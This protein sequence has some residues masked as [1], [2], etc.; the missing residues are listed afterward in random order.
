MGFRP[1]GSKRVIC[2]ILE[3]C[4][5][6]ISRFPFWSKKFKIFA[7]SGLTVFFQRFCSEY[8]KV[9][10]FCKQCRFNMENYWA[11]AMAFR[12]IFKLSGCDFNLRIKV[13]S[14]CR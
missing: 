12:I 10:T 4:A 14:A 11:H 8:A 7:T 3:L 5:D 9:S 6:S 1:V 2:F 13:V